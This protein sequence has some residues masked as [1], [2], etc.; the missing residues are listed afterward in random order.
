M[1][2]YLL[3]CLRMFK[4]IHPVDLI[5]LACSSLLIQFRSQCSVPSFRSFL[6]ILQT[7]HNLRQAKMCYILLEQKSIWFINKRE[8]Y[9]IVCILHNAHT[10]PQFTHQKTCSS[11]A[12]FLVM[13]SLFSSISCLLMR[14][15]HDFSFRVLTRAYLEMVALGKNKMLCTQSHCKISLEK[16]HMV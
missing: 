12:V 9:L 3:L 10:C 11:S 5:T 4:N 2:N 8:L 14:L 16:L 13:H 1:K 6:S 7:L 15:L